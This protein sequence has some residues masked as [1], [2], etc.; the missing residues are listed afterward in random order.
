MHSPA[1]HYAYRAEAALAHHLHALW[2][3][4]DGVH[5]ERLACGSYSK[6][7]RCALVA[8]C[9]SQGMAADESALSLLPA[10][11]CLDRQ[12]RLFGRGA[13]KALAHARRLSR[14]LI[15][16]QHDAGSGYVTRD[17][18]DEGDALA[19]QEAAQYFVDLACRRL[20]R[21]T[22]DQA[23]A[24]LHKFRTPPMTH[25]V[26]WQRRGPAGRYPRSAP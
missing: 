21:C 6:A 8:L 3:Q 2:L 19:C 17:L 18:F 4:H 14:V 15:L 23:L 13:D 11:A 20:L 7:A 12:S 22:C 5:C 10:V 16:D 26:L 24:R 25:T 9:L 1:D